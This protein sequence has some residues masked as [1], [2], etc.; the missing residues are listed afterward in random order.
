[1]NMQERPVANLG[2]STAYRSGNSR[3]GIDVAFQVGG[4]YGRRPILRMQSRYGH[5]PERF[6]L[7]AGEVDREPGVGCEGHGPRDDIVSGA[8]QNNRLLVQN[9]DS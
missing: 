6:S 7:P 3:V 5:G 1:M 2:P 9:V 8:G 4:E